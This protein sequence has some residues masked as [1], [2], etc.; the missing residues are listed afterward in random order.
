MQAGFSKVSL[1]PPFTAS[2]AGYGDRMPRHFSHVL[3][4][5]QAR[6]LAL[7][8]GE[9]R[10]VVVAAEF[11]TPT[12]RLADATR[13]KAAP[14]LPRGVEIVI[15]G[16]HT[17]SSMGNYWDHPI[18]VRVCGPYRP[19]AFDFLA[20]RFADAAVAA[21]E[22]RQAARVAFD[23]D[24][25]SLARL[26]ENRRRADGPIDPVLS[27]LSF[28]DDKGKPLGAI[29]HFAGHPVVVAERD[30]YAVSG[31]YPGRICRR[32]EEH[33]PFCLM[34]NGAVGGL[35]I[36]FPDKP[37][38]VHDHLRRVSEPIVEKSEALLSGRKA[39][40]ATIAFSRQTVEMPPNGSRPF[41]PGFWWW[42]PVL[43][44]AVWYWNRLANKGYENPRTTSVSALRIGEAAFVFHPSD[45]GVGGGLLTRDKGRAR[46]LAAIPVGHSDDYLGYVH[47]EPEM[48]IP[49][50]P[51]KDFRY[52]TI[53]ENLM[54][55]YGRGAYERFSGGETRALHAVVG[56][57]PA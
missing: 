20:S 30:F 48:L 57:H 31:D 16:T 49:P 55:F 46:G 47:P 35:S 52:L 41:P 38:D 21:W 42:S 53:Y 34:L 6:A 2:L 29:V 39:K 13:M 32:L 40:P 24:A 44:P 26:Q 8:D 50:K 17:H 11:L 1:L 56:A 5:P 22:N 10:V 3:D 15:H 14:R 27:T 7:E 36:W 43:A 25:D 33:Y 45:F 54:G 23:Q 4:D 9:T 18:A 28:V 19:E 37:I 51:G 12:D